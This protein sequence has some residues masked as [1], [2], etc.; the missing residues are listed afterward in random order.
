MKLGLRAIL[1][2]CSFGLS[3]LAHAGEPLDFIVAV[4]NDEVIVNSAFQQELRIIEE[5]LRQQKIK[6]P[7]RAELEKQVLESMVVNNLQLQ[8]AQRTGIEV[9]ENTLNETLRRYAAQ[10]QM[11]LAQLRQTIEKEGYSFTRF[12]N[13]MKNE[14]LVNKLQQRQVVSRINVTD[15]EIDSFL[16]NQEQQGNITT[17]YHLQ[18]I[19]ISVPEG[20][21]PEDVQKK[22]E[23]AQEILDKLKAGADFRETAVAMSDSQQ[24]LGG[25]DLGW[26][27]SGELPTNFAEAVAKLQK[28][29]ISPIIR[30]T[31]GFHILKLVEKRSGEKLV[32]QQT[33]ARHILIK[34]SEL[35]SDNEA[36]DR[37]LK[38]KARIAQGE[39]FA[40]LAR[41]NS[42][43]TGSAPLGGS[44]DWLSPG[45]VVPEFEEVMKTLGKNQIAE[46]FKSRFGWHLIQVLDRREYDDTDKA[47]RNRAM[48]QIRQRKL[49][50]ELQS[51]LRQ[52]REEAYVEYRLPAP[53]AVVNDGPFKIK[54]TPPAVDNN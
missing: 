47:L 15:S 50:E 6:T 21:T 2:G 8:T 16:A 14:L 30:N 34:N 17:E 41:T 53:A 9:D 10:N 43:D 12:R 25:G 23:R 29:E 44:L 37:L 5:R 51:W 24:A 40:N 4:V 11:D 32:V 1:L 46:P 3:S 26:H 20:S 28:S 19:L 39:D 35:V 7:P 33:K 13:D 36:R 42:E 45:D 38:L 27:K 49:N 48:Q 22:Q 31:G 54:G 18:H 52:L